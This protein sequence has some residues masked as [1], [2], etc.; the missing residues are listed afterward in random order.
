MLVTPKAL[1]GSTGIAILVL[2][3]AGLVFFAL[4]PGTSTIVYGDSPQITAPESGVP[5][6][7]FLREEGGFSPF[8]LRLVDSTH[9]VEVHF[10]TDPGCAPLL[11]AGE[12]WP[13]AHPECTGRVDLA[14]KVG[15]LG[16]TMS[17]R[18]LVGVQFTVPRACYEL[19]APGMAWPPGLPACHSPA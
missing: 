11:E 12:S 15:S 7:A 5:V 14:G 6:V 2:L 19:L 16:T 18:S 4:R 17:G 1:S 9:H 13:T 10:L 8:G 3:A